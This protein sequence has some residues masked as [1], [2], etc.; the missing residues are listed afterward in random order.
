MANLYQFMSLLN[1]LFIDVAG[2]V[3]KAGTPLG[4]WTQNKPLSANQLWAFEPGPYPGFFFMKSNLDNLVVDVA[5][6][7]SN[8]GTPLGVWTRKVPPSDNQLW[9]YVPVTPVGAPTA[10]GYIVSALRVSPH[11]VV[12]IRGANKARGTPLDVWTQ[13]SPASANQLW[14]VLPA[15]TNTYNPTIS[16]IVPMGRGFRITGAGLQAASPVFASYSYYVAGLPSNLE[17]GSFLCTTD[18]GGDF[19]KDSPITILDGSPGVLGIEV[20]ISFPGFS[21]GIVAQW[22]GSKFTIQR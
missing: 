8:P 5:G 11:L 6:G 12:D 20:N 18:L 15:P 13:N 7:V 21:K 19:V 3:S 1:G 17:Q 9:E 14:W 10:I 2:G 16:A 4:V 22:D